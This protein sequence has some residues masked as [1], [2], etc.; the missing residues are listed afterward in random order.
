M[1]YFMGINL[2]NSR[3][4]AELD[5]D[6]DLAQAMTL[7]LRRDIYDRNSGCKL[8]EV[9]ECDEVYFKTGHKGHP[10]AVRRES[11]F[12]LARTAFVY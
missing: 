8:K 10:E 4:A 5:L 1:L 11:S 9:V 2:S 7:T 12:D 3:I 6:V